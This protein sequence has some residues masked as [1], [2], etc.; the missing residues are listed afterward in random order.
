[1]RL[2]KNNSISQLFICFFTSLLH[3]TN[4]QDCNSSVA[5]NKNLSLHKSVKKHLFMNAISVYSMLEK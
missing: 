2:E 4:I 3:E 5:D 1:M